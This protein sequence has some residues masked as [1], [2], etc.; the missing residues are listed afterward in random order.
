MKVTYL[1]EHVTRSGQEIC[2]RDLEDGEYC[3]CDY[4]CG[5]YYMWKRENGHLYKNWKPVELGKEA[6][7]MD[8]CPISYLVEKPTFL[9]YRIGIIQ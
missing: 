3:L 9:I 2:V 7:W 5:E 8:S 1:Q 6:N 4:G